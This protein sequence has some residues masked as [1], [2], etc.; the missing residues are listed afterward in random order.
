MNIK[1][2][3][4]RNPNPK[5]IHN[6]SHFP[7]PNPMPLAY[8]FSSNHTWEKLCSH[9]RSQW[10]LMVTDRSFSVYCAIRDFR[11]STLINS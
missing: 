3:P 5:P 4:H 6:P 11:M 9:F 2:S 10:P 1:I 7:L 8:D